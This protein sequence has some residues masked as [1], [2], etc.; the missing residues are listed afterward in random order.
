MAFTVQAHAISST[1]SAADTFGNVTTDPTFRQ[2][3]FYAFVFEF[4]GRCVAHGVHSNFVGMTLHDI[5]GALDMPDSILSGAEDTHQQFMAAAEAGGGWVEYEWANLDEPDE[6]PFK[7]VAY[8]F[9][10]HRDGIEYYGGADQ[11]LLRSPAFGC[12][13]LPSGSCDI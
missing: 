3:A 7:K 5:M 1:A 8:I 11:T 13:A 4:S 2:G 12:L 10:L 6:P 9:S